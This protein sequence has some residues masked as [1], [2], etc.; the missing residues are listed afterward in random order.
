MNNSKVKVTQSTLNQLVNKFDSEVVCN[1]FEVTK[2]SDEAASLRY[3]E[4][5]VTKSKFD[6]AYAVAKTSMVGEFVKIHKT[7]RGVETKLV[8]DFDSKTVTVLKEDRAQSRVYNTREYVILNFKASAK[9]ELDEEV[10]SG[11]YPVEAALFLF[12]KSL[13][14]VSSTG[15][16]DNL[17]QSLVGKVFVDTPI[18]NIVNHLGFYGRRNEAIEGQ[19]LDQQVIIETHK[20]NVIGVEGENMT[21]C[22]CESSGKEVVAAAAFFA[23]ISEPFFTDKNNK[24]YVVYGDGARA[25]GV[26]LVNGKLVTL[27]R[28]AL[29]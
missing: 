2:F 27:N 9:P 7:R 13:S 29:T 28:M 23:S 15:D 1:H 24:K 21:F 17:I 19:D 4:A 16:L 25:A 26:D 22:K 6:A 18:Q 10:V 14:S 5:L 12:V 20:V 11:I 3:A 8:I